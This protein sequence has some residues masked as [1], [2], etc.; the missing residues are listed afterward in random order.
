MFLTAKIQVL[1][2]AL[3]IPGK[4]AFCFAYS[5]STAIKR[6]IPVEFSQTACGNFS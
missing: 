6:K 1:L 2:F 5:Y 4:V 3:Q